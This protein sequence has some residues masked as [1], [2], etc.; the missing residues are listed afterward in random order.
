MTDAIDKLQ[1]DHRSNH[2][3]FQLTRRGTPCWDRSRGFA[4]DE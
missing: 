3:V 1:N 2:G 4:D